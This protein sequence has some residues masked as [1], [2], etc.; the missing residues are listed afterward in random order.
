M[1]TYIVTYEEIYPG[2]DEVDEE[3]RTKVAFVLADSF[4]EAIQK[5]ERKFK[6]DMESVS[7]KAV[8]LDLKATIIV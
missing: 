2:A 6:G 3:V 5:T 8:T 4:K 1:K 7:I